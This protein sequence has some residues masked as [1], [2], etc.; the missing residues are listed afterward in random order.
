MS[1]QLTV[2][3][4]L[5]NL[6]V[7]ANIFVPAQMAPGNNSSGS[8]VFDM[9]SGISSALAP[10]FPGTSEELFYRPNNLGDE[11]RLE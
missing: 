8:F 6:L 10:T 4:F 2:R 3:D 5:R 9:L 7:F 11:L 1:Q